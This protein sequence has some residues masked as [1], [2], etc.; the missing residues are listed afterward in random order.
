MTEPPNTPAGDAEAWHLTDAQ[1][2]TYLVRLW[3]HQRMQVDAAREDSERAGE[4]HYWLGLALAAALVV[5]VLIVLT[6]V[7]T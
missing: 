4:R 1:R 2:E 6:E 5:A 7:L 3:A